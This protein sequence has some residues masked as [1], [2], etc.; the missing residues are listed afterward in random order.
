MEIEGISEGNFWHF[1]HPTWTFE[2]TRITATS[3]CFSARGIP[4]SDLP[5]LHLNQ[6]TSWR[7][8]TCPCSLML[9]GYESYEMGKS[10]PWFLGNDMELYSKVCIYIYTIATSFGGSLWTNQS[11]SMSDIFSNIYPEHEPVFQVK[12]S[13]PG[14]FHGMRKKPGCYLFSDA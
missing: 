8:S 10:T 6:S 2:V 11:N 13:A 5:H 4:K 9:V 7:T 3:R 14:E 12:I 1:D